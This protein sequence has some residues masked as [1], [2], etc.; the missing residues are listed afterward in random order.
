MWK[1]IAALSIIVVALSGCAT[2]AVISDL[3]E[4]KVKVQATGNDMSVI[5]AEA[6][7][8]CSIHDR[9]P[10]SISN[11]CL[12]NYCVTKEYLFACKATK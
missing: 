3:E 11:R 10:I 9:K 1:S 8:G 7:N 2:R 5:M 12:D 6:S 4:D